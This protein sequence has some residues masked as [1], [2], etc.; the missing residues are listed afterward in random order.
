MLEID[1]PATKRHV[2]YRNAVAVFK[3]DQVVGYVP[4]NLAASI[5]QETFCRSSW[6]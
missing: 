6:R 1:N 5:S 4:F 3:E 2:A